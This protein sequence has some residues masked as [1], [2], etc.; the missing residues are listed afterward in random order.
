VRT[1]IKT[2]QLIKEE[3]RRVFLERSYFKLKKEHPEDISEF[4]SDKK[5]EVGRANITGTISNR[6]LEFVEYLYE[7]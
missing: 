5:I 2:F 3:E 1:T 4:N 7:I 6:G